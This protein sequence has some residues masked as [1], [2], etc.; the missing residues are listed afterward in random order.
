MSIHFAQPDGLTRQSWFVLS[1]ISF[2]IAL[3]L[4]RSELA[5]ANP[6]FTDPSPKRHR[7][8]QWFTRR[9]IIKWPNLAG[10]HCI[11][12]RVHERPIEIE[13]LETVRVLRQHEL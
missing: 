12:I 8:P 4:L 11:P 6:N 13:L 9:L 7:Q 3:N 2:E 10:G 1:A 5:R